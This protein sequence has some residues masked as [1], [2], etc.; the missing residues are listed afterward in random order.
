MGEGSVS[1]APS[2]GRLSWNVGSG[3]GLCSVESSP[4]KLFSKLKGED[5]TDAAVAVGISSKPSSIKLRVGDG[6]GEIVG[7]AVV[8]G[9]EVI[10]TASCVPAKALGWLLTWLS[11]LHGI[12]LVKASITKE[13]DIITAIISDWVS[14]PL[15]FLFITYLNS[16]ARNKYF[17][18]SVILT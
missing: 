1:V 4:P 10:S 11:S 2:P 12:V 13:K 14:L 16:I 6:V 3:L 17:A 8:L 15:D 18:S 9:F 7:V 5:D